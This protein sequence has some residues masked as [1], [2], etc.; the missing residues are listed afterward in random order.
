MIY[1]I[2]S[3][4]VD[5]IS[6]SFSWNCNKVGFTN[7]TNSTQLLKKFQN[8]TNWVWKCFLFHFWNKIQRIKHQLTSFFAHQTSLTPKNQFWR[9]RIEEVMR[10]KYID[11]MLWSM[12]RRIKLSIALKL[13]TIE[14]FFYNHFVALKVVTRYM[15]Y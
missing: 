3:S 12:Q 4:S 11:A 6:F 5:H 15:I 2:L 13:T 10:L 8:T 14:I 7:V 1:N 9:S